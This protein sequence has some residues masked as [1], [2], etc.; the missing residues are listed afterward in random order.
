MYGVEDTGM[1]A[2]NHTHPTMCLGEQGV[3][4]EDGLETQNKERGCPELVYNLGEGWLGRWC[5]SS[6]VCVFEVWYVWVLVCGRGARLVG[7][8][9]V[10]ASFLE[11]CIF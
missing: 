2:P 9:L 1:G 6:G 4:W 11:S 8:R 3:R 7:G 5:S 10:A